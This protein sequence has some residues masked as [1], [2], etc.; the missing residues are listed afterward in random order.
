[1]ESYSHENIRSKIL[2]TRTLGDLKTIALFFISAK[3]LKYDINM[4][5]LLRILSIIKEKN[6]ISNRI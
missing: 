1:M 2:K 3:I 5:S 4:L 6:V